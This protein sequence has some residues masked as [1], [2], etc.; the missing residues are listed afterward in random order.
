M[1]ELANNQH[2]IDE[3]AEQQRQLIE[4][5]LNVL[6]KDISAQD[7]TTSQRLN[8]ATKMLSPYVR[9]LTLEHTVQKAQSPSTAQDAF[10]SEVRQSMRLS[11]EEM[12]VDAPSSHTRIEK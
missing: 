2:G 10:F 4:H 11:S 6:L 7:L 9:M 1:N 3:R 5:T 8:F 12:T